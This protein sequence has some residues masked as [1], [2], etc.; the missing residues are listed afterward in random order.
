MASNAHLSRRAFGATAVATGVLAHL[1]PGVAQAAPRR[2]GTLVATWGGPEPQA[3]YVPTGGGYGPTF[4][5]AKLFE[6]LAKRNMDGGF[7]GVLA[8]SWKPSADFKSYT[9]AVRPGVTWHD[10]RPMTVNDVVYSIGE[11][12]TKYAIAP[13]LA[14]FAGVEATDAGTVVVH[15]S[16]PMPELYF[17]AIITGAI[18][19]IVPGTSM[20][21]PMS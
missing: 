3:C 20:P 19:Y 12:W 16:K 4:T 18:S 9:I 15:F 14:D 13:A 5:S 17:G 10:G 11:L 1:E 7:S 21:A 6:R 8:T 2:G